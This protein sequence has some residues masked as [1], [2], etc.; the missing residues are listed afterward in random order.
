MPVSI[1]SNLLRRIQDTLY[2]P[3]PT[4]AQEMNHA[5]NDLGHDHPATMTAL[6]PE[7]SSREEATDSTHIARPGLFSD[8]QS[9]TPSTSPSFDNYT[10]RPV[11]ES[12]T[13]RRQSSNLAT[14]S[15]P[16]VSA[17]AALRKRILEIQIL[18]LPEREKARR[19]QVYLSLVST[20]ERLAIDDRG[21]SGSPTTA[22]R[23]EFGTDATR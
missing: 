11:P 14:T 7:P 2:A 10:S 8:D 5:T 22:K 20:S 15:A 3:S 13:R 16:D 19:V 1:A 6:D 9:P 23:L 17:Q 18:N 21:L 4:A 12:S